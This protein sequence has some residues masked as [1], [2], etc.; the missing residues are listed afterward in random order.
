MAS[1]FKTCPCPNKGRCPHAWTVRYREPGGRCGRA[2]H[3][4]FPTKKLATAFATTVEHDKLAGTYLDPA[5]SQIRLA[6]YAAGWLTTQPLR[7]G[8]LDSYRR[9]LRNHIHPTLGHHPLADLTRDQIQAWTAHLTDTGL[10]PRTIHTIYGLLATILR[11]AVLDNRLPRTPCIGIH[12]PTPSPTTVRILTPD[13][14]QA[15][16]D[17]MPPRYA[18]TVLF[19]YGTGTR[20]G[21]TFAASRTRINHQARTYTVDRQ[22]ILINTKAD[23]YSAQPAFGPPKTKAGHR[24]IPLPQFVIDALAEHEPHTHPGQDLLFTGPRTG[25]AL[26]R[27]HYGPKIFTPAV[28]KAGL[29]PDTTF[30]DLRHSYAA[31]TLAAGIPILDVARWL[32]HATTTETTTTYGHLLPEAT[33]RTRDA[34]DQA[35]SKTNHLTRPQPDSEQP[36][37]DR[38]EGAAEPAT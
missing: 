35:W 17:A 16:A 23:G 29:P 19:A 36:K 21:E 12:L 6:D 5:R 2:R 10:A 26:H 22:I 30:H 28:A 1:V 11:T 7:P 37:D 15:L 14:V 8:T 33:T 34:L 18:A 13:Q 27:N 9:N 38:N 20:Q 31:T 24:T 3:R 25:T 32:G 4:S